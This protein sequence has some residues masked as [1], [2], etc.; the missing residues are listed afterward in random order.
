MICEVSA[1]LRWKWRTAF[2]KADFSFT[3][4][5]RA[6]PVIKPRDGTGIRAI[7]NQR[8]DI[9]AI[10]GGIT[11]RDKM[12]ASGCGANPLLERGKV[13]KAETEFSD[14]R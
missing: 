7:L 4:A 14:L 6:W 8:N 5:P 10:G 12:L 13:F 3:Q 2:S 11:N 9:E 1:T